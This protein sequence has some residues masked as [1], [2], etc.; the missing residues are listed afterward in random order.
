VTAWRCL[1]PTEQEADR[2]ALATFLDPAIA[3]EIAAMPVV[4]LSE[5]LAPFALR[6]DAWLYRTDG[7]LRTSRRGEVYEVAA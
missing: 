2:R 6:C 5:Q 1:T 7:L 3:A 4:D